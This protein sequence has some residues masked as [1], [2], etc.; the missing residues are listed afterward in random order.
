MSRL[1][2]ER[3]ENLTADYLCFMP[4]R[5]TRPPV[6]LFDNPVRMFS[7][8]ELAQ[9]VRILERA[10]PGQTVEEL[11][12]AVFRE[13]AMKRTQ[14]AVEL[15]AEAIRVARAQRARD[16]ISGS[17]WQASTQEVREWAVRN[18]F[19]LGDDGGIPE[20]AITAYNQIHPNRPY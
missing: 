8:D 7:L 11:S 9:T 2:H 12:S 1:A 3:A 15:V 10:R 6:G 19:D 20:H 4:P 5:P 17:Q 16:E 14:R 13:L 18:G